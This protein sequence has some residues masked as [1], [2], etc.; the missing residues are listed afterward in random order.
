MDPPSLTEFHDHAPWR[1][2]RLFR[3][4]RVDDLLFTDPGGEDR[5][6]YGLSSPR[7]SEHHRFA[8]TSADLTSLP[9][10]NHDHLGLGHSHA[11]SVPPPWTEALGAQALTA[12]T[13]RSSTNASACRARPASTCTASPPRVRHSVPPRSPGA[14]FRRSSSIAATVE[15]TSPF[16]R[17]PPAS[18]RHRHRQV[19]QAGSRT[20]S[21]DPYLVGTIRS[22]YVRPGV[23]GVRRHARSLR[24]ASSQRRDLGAGTQRRFKVAT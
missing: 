24:G 1:E 2:P 21:E 8:R 4:R 17:R 3:R 9:A 15:P 13:F 23:D 16:R 7:L 10:S 22:A 18:P 12:P 19:A 6:L 5:P 11:P 14:T 20:I